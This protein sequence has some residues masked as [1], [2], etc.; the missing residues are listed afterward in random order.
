MLVDLGPGVGG[1]V[2]DRW[3]GV[4]AAPYAQCNLAR[5]VGDDPTAVERNRRTVA[6]RLGWPPDRVAWM[7]QVHGADVAV[8]EHPR[9]DAV[10]GVDALVA[11]TPGLALAVLVAD[12]TPVLL[13]DPQAKLIAV[14]HAGRRG[15]QLGVVPATV[16]R[17]VALGARPAALRVF[18]GPAVCGSCY[19][20]PAAMQAEVVED[21]PSSAA[22]TR[23]GTPALDIRA[24][25]RGQLAE[26]GVTAVVTSGI[27]TAEDPAYYS[28]R[29][30]GVTGRFAGYLWLRPA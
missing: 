19:E 10:A 16:R 17:M 27:C 18:L 7:D 29:R 14:A 12:C 8:V 24:G 15:M 6:Q 3:G 1:A 9:P 22:R 26:L 21:V 25:I 5:H 23:A 2:P 28:V 20:V 30:D 13:A 4:S 11:T